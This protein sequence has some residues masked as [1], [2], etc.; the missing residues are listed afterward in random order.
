[1]SGV[2]SKE[3]GTEAQ[4]TCIPLCFRKQREDPES[5]ISDKDLRGGMGFTGD[6]DS[7]I[8]SGPSGTHGST[9]LVSQNA[10]LYSV[11][12]FPRSPPRSENSVDLRVQSNTINIGGYWG[13]VDLSS[14]IKL[15]HKVRSQN[16]MFPLLVSPAEAERHFQDKSAKLNSGFDAIPESPGRDERGPALV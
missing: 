6:P 16:P 7:I 8:S 5:P 11:R 12:S 14:V 1:M 4:R 2:S 9:E 10:E 15:R 3:S 13:E